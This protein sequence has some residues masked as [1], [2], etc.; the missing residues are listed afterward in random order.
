[1]QHRNTLPLSTEQLLES[2]RAPASPPPPAAGGQ[3]RRPQQRGR[4][5]RAVKSQA[6]NLDLL[7]RTIEGG[8]GA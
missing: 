5:E 8:G 3:L 2:L 6:A 4:T 7:L 1:M